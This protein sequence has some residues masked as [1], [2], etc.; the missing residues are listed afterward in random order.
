L[1]E[2]MAAPRSGCSTGTTATAIPTSPDAR[3][4]AAARI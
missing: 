4:T 2:E 3:D 1:N